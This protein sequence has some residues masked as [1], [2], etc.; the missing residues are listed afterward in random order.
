MRLKHQLIIIS[1]FT[2][3]IPWTAGEFMKE[4]EFALRQSAQSSLLSTARAMAQLITD[5]RSDFHQQALQDLVSASQHYPPERTVFQANP[6]RTPMTI[7]GYADE[8]RELG[9]LEYRY[10]HHLDKNIKD[11]QAHLMF[12]STADH[13]YTTL[14][15]YD[16]EILPK[17][18][19]EQGVKPYDFIRFNTVDEHQQSLIFEIASN[20][21]GPLRIQ[22]S[23]LSA[24]EN[25]RIIS[26]FWQDTING[27]RLELMI[28][29]PLI[30]HGFGFIIFD[31]DNSG[32]ARFGSMLKKLPSNK[33]A[34]SEPEKIQFS[35]PS[36]EN[37]IEPFKRLRT[38]IVLINRE[39]WIQ[40]DTNIQQP[41]LIDTP[42]DPLFSNTDS[43]HSSNN[44]HPYL[45]GFYQWLMAESDQPHTDNPLIVNN[46]HHLYGK[47]IDDLMQGATIQTW[48]PSLSPTLFQTQ[49]Y[50]QRSSGAHIIAAYPIIF[51][52]VVIGGI[53]LIEPHKSILSLANQAT[54]KIILLSL[55]VVLAILSILLV[56]ATFLS[57]RIRQLNH[58]IDRAL[59]Q[60]ELKP[61]N[62]PLLSNSRDE[63]GDLYRSFGKLFERIEQYT[64][65]LKLLPKTLSHELRTP[66]AIVESSL[67]NLAQLNLTEVAEPYL[68]RA[69]RGNDRQ[70]KI[71]NTLGEAQYLEESIHK[72]ETEE[73]S[74]KKISQD[75]ISAYQ[76]LHP[77]KQ[78]ELETQSDQGFF[79]DGSPDLLA[80]MLEKLLSNAVDFTPDTGVIKITLSAQAEYYSL[81]LFNSG[82]Q[83]PAGFSDKLFQSMISRR[84]DDSASE[85]PHLGLGLYIVKLICEA[86]QAS[87]SAE[88]HTQQS[89]VKFTFSFPAKTESRYKDLPSSL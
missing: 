36:I 38:R 85:T 46:Q 35:N 76:E 14:H 69:K 88:N 68:Q 13:I 42:E 50:S 86:H 41:F 57:H 33:I 75:L 37:L 23:S 3:F 25:D 82:S 24:P 80:Q 52:R 78:F 31:A 26:G 30:Q 63:I 1:L 73:L 27:Y 62:L 18:T 66:L 19:T 32:E 10:Y 22:A 89:G 9:Y 8:W 83:L 58:Y 87:Y 34:I 71:L 74:L 28:P 70:R 51:D 4:L 7:D 61:D 54:L 81:T 11:R 44:A 55:V 2:L 17:I 56:F 49:G 79:I 16:D 5:N 59:T 67:D 20:A 48:A 21:P 40:T 84:P 72:F 45:T 12:C 29:K 15:I 6:C 39:G 77:E 53:I 64:H 47:I 65:Y 60:S 43:V